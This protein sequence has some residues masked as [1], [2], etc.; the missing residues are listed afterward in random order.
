MFGSEISGQRQNG[1]HVMF[2][3]V[4]NGSLHWIPIFNLDHTLIKRV[5]VLYKLDVKIFYR[6]RLRGLV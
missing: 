1:L 3:C 6:L 5:K 2:Q 4:G